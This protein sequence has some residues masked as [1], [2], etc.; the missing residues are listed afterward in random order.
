MTYNTNKHL[1]MTATQ[2]SVPEKLNPGVTSTDVICIIFGG[3]K[4]ESKAG[5]CK[6]NKRLGDH[7]M[8]KGDFNDTI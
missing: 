1:V 3:V 6:R 4:V 8:I 5:N 2:F 7:V